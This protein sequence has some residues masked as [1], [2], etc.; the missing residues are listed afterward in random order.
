MNNHFAKP[1]RLRF[2]LLFFF[3][4]YPCP[5]LRHLW[6]TLP[7]TQHNLVHIKNFSC[8][9]KFPFLR[10]FLSSTFQTAVVQTHHMDVP[11]R[12]ACVGVLATPPVQRAPNVLATSTTSRRP[13]A[14]GA[15]VPHS[16]TLECLVTI[17]QVSAS[18]RVGSTSLV[19]CVTNA[20][21]E[22]TEECLSS[23]RISILR[24]QLFAVL[25]PALPKDQPPATVSPVTVRAKRLL[26]ETIAIG[27]K[28]TRE[29]KYGNLFD[30]IE[31]CHAV[32]NSR[33]REN[34]V[35]ASS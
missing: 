28:E 15:G 30:N 7:I 3:F 14:A 21:K 23:H 5:P 17:S 27:E 13:G 19:G 32:L 12:P 16:L 31:N 34:F 35:L 22:P 26:P 2:L 6:E 33:L 24:R 1:K 11:Q 29:G 10:F 20:R 9:F 4:F 18:V 25:A 8:S